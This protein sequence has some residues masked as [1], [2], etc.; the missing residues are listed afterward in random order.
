MTEGA[1]TG[2]AAA[3]H[4]IEQRRVAVHRRLDEIELRLNRIRADRGEWTDEEHDPEG[5][6]LVHEWSRAEGARAEHQREL[7]ELSAAESRLDEG[8]YGVCATCGRPIPLEQLA[9]RPARRRCVACTDRGRGR[10]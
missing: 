3:R 5:F 10:R 7:V 6:T 9:L 4:R 8:G 2:A 1:G